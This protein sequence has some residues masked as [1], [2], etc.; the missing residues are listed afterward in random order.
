[1]SENI[2]VAEQ[3]AEVSAEAPTLPVESL[4]NAIER[5]KNTVEFVPADQLDDEAPKA[6]YTLEIYADGTRGWSRDYGEGTPKGTFEVNP[7][8]SDEAAA[9][10]DETADYVRTQ[11]PTLKGIA[12]QEGRWWVGSGAEIRVKKG[13][14][15]IY[16]VIDGDGR[17]EILNCSGRELTDIEK[18]SIVKVFGA[19]SSLTGGKIYDRVKGIV[20]AP[21]E[22][23]DSKEVDYTNEPQKIIGDF[24]HG[25]GIVRM[26]ADY[27]QSA[28]NAERYSPYFDGQPVDI[29]EMILAHELGHAM[30]IKTLQEVDQ[31]GIDKTK[32]EWSSFGEITGD[33][34]SFQQLAGWLATQKVVGKTG[35]L[36][37]NVWSFDESETTECAPTNYGGT[38]PHEDFAETFAIIAMGGDRSKLPARYEQL[39]KTIQIA[40]GQSAIGPRKASIKPVSPEDFLNKKITQAGLKVFKKKQSGPNPLNFV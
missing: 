28:E 18:E 17:V 10:F 16:E 1:M 11:K 5:L 36:R 14:N 39:A 21:D 35:L 38:K 40:E 32:Q 30:D 7:D 20:F 34:S 29:F 12:E 33:F 22:D 15:E 8:E 37:E 25:S 19:V 9:I 31:H 26:N 27:I 24:N 23:F 6:R 4:E 3:S 13:I 2:A